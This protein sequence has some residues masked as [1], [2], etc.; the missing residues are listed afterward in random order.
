MRDW[1]NVLTLIK[2]EHAEQRE[3]GLRNILDAQIDMQSVSPELVTEL[4]EF[5]ISPERSEPEQ[6][7]KSISRETTFSRDIADRETWINRQP[8]NSLNGGEDRR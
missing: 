8:D 5:V 4:A 6:E 1:K 3:A 2:S 7:T